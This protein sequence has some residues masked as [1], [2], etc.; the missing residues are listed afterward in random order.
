V[1]VARELGIAII[2][3]DRRGSRAGSF[4]LRCDTRMAPLS[5]TNYPAPDSDALVLHVSDTTGRPKAVPLSH[6]NVSA[7][8]RFTATALDLGPADRCL[9]AGPLFHPHGLVTALLAP[10]TAGGTVTC[11]PGFQA[12][13]FFGWLDSC[14]PTWYT[15]SP[16]IHQAIV[17]RV[18][19]G[20]RVR[21]S[22]RFVRSSE[23][24]LPAHLAADLERVFGVPVIDG[25][26]MREA[27]P[28]MDLEEGLTEREAAACVAAVITQGI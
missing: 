7:A 8:V 4:D 10:L 26:G 9:N 14:Q 24:P 1:D 27:S 25:Y 15:A 17:D 11:M 21:S 12:A 3:L 20:T 2:E 22:L 28:L 13:E 23:A 6:A 18:A 19:E 16:P 5:M